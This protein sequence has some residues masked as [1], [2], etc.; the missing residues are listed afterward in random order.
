MTK[1]VAAMLVLCLSLLSF[2]GCAVTTQITNTSRSSIEEKLLMSALERA[3][4]GLNT[5]QFRG[6]TV[7]VDFY[8]LSADKD[9]AKAFFI[10][11]LQSHQV[12]IAPNPKEAQLLLKVFAPVLAV[13]QGKSFIGAPSFMVPL[14]GITVPEIS[15]FKDVRHSGHAELRTYAID[16][17]TGKFVD[18]SSPVVGAA[19]YDDYTILLVI[20]FTRSDI[21]GSTWQWQPEGS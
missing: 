8:G 18:K 5:E 9:F 10:A 1:N 6:K 16:V 12:Q 4:S 3:L 13:D 2:E 11:W 7:A 21:G 15:L 17:H 20:N 14:L 19:R